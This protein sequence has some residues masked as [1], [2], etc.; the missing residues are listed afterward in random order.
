[1]GYSD[2]GIGALAIIKNNQAGIEIVNG[3]HDFNFSGGYSLIDDGASLAKPAD[4]KVCV[5]PDG[6]VEKVSRRMANVVH[7]WL[8]LSNQALNVA[9]RLKVC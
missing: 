7:R 4:H 5:G 1:M 3:S 6:I 9:A 2:A 8:Y